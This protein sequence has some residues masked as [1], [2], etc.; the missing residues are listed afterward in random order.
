MTELPKALQEFKPNEASERTEL[1]RRRDRW[2][3]A[4]CLAVGCSSI[5][6]LFLLLVSIAYQGSSSLNGTFLSAS[7]DPENP[8]RAGMYPSIV[9][10]VILCTLCAI[11]SLPIGVAAA[12]YLEEFQPKNRWLLRL[13]GLVQ[14]NIAN[15]AG[16]PSVVYGLLGLTLFVYMFQ[17]FGKLEQN[18]VSGIDFWGIQ[19]YYQFVTADDL[20]VIFV[21][22]DESR[23]STLK[24]ESVRPAFDTNFRPIELQVWDPATPQ[25]TDPE[26]LGRTVRKGDVGALVEI[27]SW[28]YF[29]LPFGPSLLA[30]ALTLSLVILPI[31]V[32]ASQE[33]L[34]AVPS[35]MREAS[36]GM[37]ATRW[38]TTQ[39]VTLPAALPGVLT[40][41]ILAMGRAIGEAAPIFVVLGGNIAKRTGPEHLMDSCVT[42]P[43]LIFAWADNPVEQYRQLA[44]AAIIVL[45]ALLL[46]MNSMAIYLRGRS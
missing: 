19:R 2:F 23:E 21:L 6:I 37:G 10:S 17:L 11:I 3:R 36:A 20:A 35:S 18:Q 45:V 43:I 42:M 15:L 31:I 22:M 13:H 38:Q 28:Y 39:Q 34:R 14:L 9:G 7:H 46:V 4:L 40:G 5:A 29:R 8:A 26:V 30:A 24:I 41:A 32:I 12:V 25:P 16:V 44:A 33:A 1:Q 27:Y